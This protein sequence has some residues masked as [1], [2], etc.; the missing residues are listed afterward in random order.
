MNTMS[1]T[2]ETPKMKIMRIKWDPQIEENY[3]FGGKGIIVT[4]YQE[5]ISGWGVVKEIIE[6][7]INVYLIH[8]NNGIMLRV[9]NPIEVQITKQD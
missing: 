3:S 9:I 7:S 5:A 4:K 6:E 1:G 8:Y 2:I